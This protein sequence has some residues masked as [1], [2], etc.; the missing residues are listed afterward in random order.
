MFAGK[1]PKHCLFLFLINNYSE[2]FK[3]EEEERAAGEERTKLRKR[4]I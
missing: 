3:F 1:E 4:K 2:K